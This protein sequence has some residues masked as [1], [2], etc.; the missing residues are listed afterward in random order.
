M[1]PSLPD[2]QV[3]AA[4]W[5]AEAETLRRWGATQQATALDACADRLLGWWEEELYRR[6]STEEAAELS[7]YTRSGLERLRAEGKLTNAGEEGKPAYLL[8]E[9]PR[10]P[11]PF[12]RRRSRADE[13]EPDLAKEILALRRGARRAS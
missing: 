4:E 3:L 1:R 5:K 6:V 11:K 12:L 7:G 10:K 2:P 13:A 9:L 8:G